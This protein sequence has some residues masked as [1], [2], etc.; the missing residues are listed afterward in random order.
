MSWG[1]YVLGGI[2]SGGK[3]LRGKCLGGICPWGK[4]PVIVSLFLSC[5][6]FQKISMHGNLLN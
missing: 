1:V 6:P 4:C 2:C 5:Q 3:C